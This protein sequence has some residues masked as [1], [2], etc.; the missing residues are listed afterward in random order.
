MIDKG[1]FSTANYD[2]GKLLEINEILFE[3]VKEKIDAEIIVGSLAWGMQNAVNSMSDLDLVLI[4]TMD[5]LE[6]L[7]NTKYFANKLHY[8]EV[9][10]ILENKHA[11]FLFLKIDIEGVRV[12]IDLIEKEYFIYMCSIELITQKKGVIAWK[13]GNEPQTNE[14]FVKG[15]RNQY[16]L[17]NKVSEIEKSG[18]RIRLPLFHVFPNERNKFEYYYGIPTIKL[19]TSVIFYMSESYIEISLQM[20]LKQLIFRMKDEALQNNM[21]YKIEEYNLLNLFVFRK[22]MDKKIEK[23]FDIRLE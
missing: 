14:Y 23:I 21:I 13:Y 19:L 18:Y 12:S 17:V 9:K 10:Q 20:L 16:K 11:D 15:F 8:V 22:K 7:L 6:E 5:K 1:F 4:Y 2:A 3:S